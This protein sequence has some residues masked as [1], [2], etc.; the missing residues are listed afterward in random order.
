[1]HHE[2]LVSEESRIL[3]LWL[4]TNIPIFRLL[5]VILI[6]LQKNTI[7]F[8]SKCSSMMSPSFLHFVFNL[9]T[10]RSFFVTNTPRYMNL[11]YGSH[12]L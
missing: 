3:L 12:H 5:A 4:L 2:I 9:F 7:L 10:F 8:F 6:Q 1:M 11:P